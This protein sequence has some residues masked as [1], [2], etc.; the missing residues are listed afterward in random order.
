MG[1]HEHGP[2]ISSAMSALAW[3]ACNDPE[4]ELRRAAAFA[5]AREVLE[6]SEG[7]G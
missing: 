7:D 1:R 2:L 5:L 3:L 4:A 6:V